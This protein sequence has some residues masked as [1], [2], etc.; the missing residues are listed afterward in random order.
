MNDSR[1]YIV[2]VLIVLIAVV[3]ATKLFS[4]QVLNENYRLAAESN[5]VQEIVE[6]PY[7]GLVYD[8]DGQL[9]VYNEPNYDLMV[10]PKEVQQM[11]TLAFCKTFEMSREK[12]ISGMNE[13]RRYSYIK[14]SVFIKQISSERFAQVQDQLM[15]YPGFYPKARTV[16]KYPYDGLANV[17]GYIGEISGRR[18]KSDTTNYYRS[19]DY[20]GIT[21]LESQY[22]KD[23]RGKRGVK[24]KM[25]NVRGIEKG[26]FKDGK[27]DT[28]AIPGNDVHLSIDLE[29]QKYA[30]QL[31]KGKIGSVVA[32]EPS[33]GEILSFVSS[34]SYDPNLLAGRNFGSNY[35]EI[36]NDSL[37]PLFNRPLMAMYPPGS[38]FKIVQGLIALQEGVVGANEQIYCDN[39]LIGD[40]APPGSYDMKKA[41]RNSSNNYFFKVFKR[42]VNRGVPGDPKSQFKQ[43][44][45]G[46]ERWHEMVSAFGLGRP[47][48]IDLPNEG[49][50]VIPDPELYNRLYGTRRWK[51]SNIYSL[52][53]G[54]GEILMNP[55]QMT[56][57]AAIMANKGY[58]YIPHIA[59]GVGTTKYLD[60]H[61]KQ[62]VDTGID[63]E[64]FPVIIDGMEE[65]LYGTA[66][67]AII[68]DIVICGKTG[69]AENPHG[70]D[71]S[72]F[73]A[74]APKENPQIAI[75]VFVENAGWGG[76]A[77]ASIAS[78]LIEQHVRGSVTRPWLEDYVLKGEF[79]Y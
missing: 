60:P 13:A 2:R 30:E 54:Q 47:L 7:R 12:F 22:E 44:P 43:A 1:K 25:V 24:Y 59:K 10:V 20:I 11:D 52:S 79:I 9:A 4:I 63:A 42:F 33:S 64:H 15:D 72:V 32:I 8:R 58:Y 28:L 71:H 29:L 75:S 62:K 56:N 65:A 67:R 40:H 3:F 17:F 38:I 50:G 51:F 76:R 69:T 78:L 19:G 46:L 31:M 41:I 55:I 57:L 39:S 73:M 49:A 36:V 35:G 45:I 16:R 61:Y 18:L 34:P 74:F 6:Y 66:G 27:L 53:I 14:P 48:G 26:S 68:S 23:L 21:G 77:A 5:I 37:K 70:E